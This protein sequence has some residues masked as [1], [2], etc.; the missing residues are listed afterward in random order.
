MDIWLSP[1]VAILGVLRLKVLF[2]I[3]EIET[4]VNLK[5]KEAVCLEL[6]LGWS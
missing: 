1:E 6:V 4:V 2:H 3:S 5:E